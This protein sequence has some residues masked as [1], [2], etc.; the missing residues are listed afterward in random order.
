[1]LFATSMSLVLES[2]CSTKE[3]SEEELN[4]LERC[5]LDS[6]NSIHYNR[7]PSI[8]PAVVCDEAGVARG[9]YWII[10]NAA[11]LDRLRPIK[12]GM[13]R[14]ARIFDVLRQTGVLAAA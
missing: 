4:F 7:F 3:I 1:M 10:C 5:W 14:S 13:N 8:A 11:I 9:N 2:Y 12:R 6:L